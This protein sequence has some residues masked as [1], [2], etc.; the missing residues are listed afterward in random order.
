MLL[1]TTYVAAAL[2]ATLTAAGSTGAFAADGY[3][4][5]ESRYGTATISA[6]VRRGGPTGME[7][8]LP[9]GTWIDCHLSCSE[10]LRRETIDFWQNHRGNGENGG[11][12]G[13]GYFRWRR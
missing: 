1:R 10:A 5:A 11:N 6:P 7:V 4:T 9:G 2:V 12:D 13:P 3:V 8:R